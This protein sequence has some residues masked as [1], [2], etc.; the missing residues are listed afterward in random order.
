MNEWKQAYGLAKI[1]LSEMKPFVLYYSA[2]IIYFVI[3]INGT[4]TDY[5]DKAY[6]GLDILFA[7]LFILLPRYLR[8]RYFQWMALEQ[9]WYAS[10]FHIALS[11]LP[12][13]NKVIAKYHY[14]MH[15]VISLPIQLS[16][17]IA[18]YVSSEAFRAQLSLSSFIVF[19][20]FWLSINLFLGASGSFSAVGSNLFIN[21]GLFFL[22][23]I[24]FFVAGTFIFYVAFTD[25]IVGW[26]IYMAE[27]H[28]LLTVII[29]ILLTSVGPKMW[30]TLTV[31][32]MSRYNYFK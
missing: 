26:T 12:V 8:K 24:V 13:K 23:A 16:I 11:S 25:G 27:A 18:V 28:T 7:L 15:A 10:H 2:L 29:A 5:F 17:L 6:F 30:T 3:L 32:K 1:E 9:G 31:L 14:L 20:I 21:A 19:T 22:A 4:A